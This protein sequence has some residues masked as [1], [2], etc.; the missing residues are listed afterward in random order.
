MA[1]GSL[2]GPFMRGT[3]PLQTVD[4]KTSHMPVSDIES[5]TKQIKVRYQSAIWTDWSCYLHVVKCWLWTA[6]NAK[7]GRCVEWYKQGRLPTKY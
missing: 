5:C 1:L 7:E 3:S 6:F 4:H 2:S